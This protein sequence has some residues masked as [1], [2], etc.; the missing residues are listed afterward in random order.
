M[1]L[2]LL[3]A[4]ATVVSPSPKNNAPVPPAIAATVTDF[5]LTDIHG[6]RHSLSDYKNKKAIVV[7]FVGTE[8][9]IANL[10]YPTLKEMHKGYAEKGVQLLAI[11]S[12]DQDS[13]AEVVAHARERAL[14]FPVL[15]DAEHKAA[16][17]L[18]ARRTPEAFL[19]DAGKVIRYHGRIDDQYGYTY[20]RAA[21][22]KTEL[23][24][25]IEEILAGK[26]VTTPRTDVQGCVIGRKKTSDNSQKG[27][28][29]P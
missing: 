3:P 16:D 11:N 2:T 13:L 26:P 25:A 7:V 27:K 20:R 22:A 6:R 19:L 12:N 10:Y 23:K 21:P 24:D 17:A 1:W 4:L 14:P 9:P 5:T 18:G 8:C 15:K 28:G 29:T